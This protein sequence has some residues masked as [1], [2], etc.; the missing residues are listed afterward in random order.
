MHGAVAFSFAY[1]VS[2]SFHVQ[3][4]TVSDNTI[5]PWSIHPLD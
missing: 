5:D 2:F 4:D 3:F 1:A